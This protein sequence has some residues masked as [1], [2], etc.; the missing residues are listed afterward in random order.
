MRRLLLLLLV[1]LLQTGVDSS[2]AA[3]DSVYDH[4]E[5]VNQ[6]TEALARAK[7]KA[8]AASEAM[9]KVD[10]GVTLAIAQK[11]QKNSED[12]ND[13][14]SAAVVVDPPGGGANFVAKFP[15][16][17]KKELPAW[18]GPPT[19]SKAAD[20]GGGKT[21]EARLDDGRT[22]AVA[23][24]PTEGS[25]RICPPE[26]TVQP[27]GCRADENQFFINGDYVSEEQARVIIADLKK[28]LQV[29]TERM[30]DNERRLNIQR[31]KLKELK[32]REKQLLEEQIK[33]P[34]RFTPE[35]R[36]AGRQIMLEK[37][38]RE[39]REAEGDMLGGAGDML[40][41][42]SMVETTLVTTLMRHGLSQITIANWMRSILGIDRRRR[43]VTMLRWR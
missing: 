31:K 17:I 23:A 40:V 2:S 15:E 9:D 32:L 5:A 6:A 7:K 42:G 38:R 19:L 14:D 12:D 11:N 30:K 18:Q 1:S 34:E 10:A 35:A 28:Q 25:S 13:D 29:E 26:G 21:V 33:H 39:D 24:V 4:D 16:E 8:R 22:V 43:H 37:K 41:H 3:A 27:A 20:P 36:A